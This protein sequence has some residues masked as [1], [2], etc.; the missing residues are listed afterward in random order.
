[1]EISDPSQR[2]CLL[3]LESAFKLQEQKDFC[4]HLISSCS[5]SLCDDTLPRRCVH[6]TNLRVDLYDPYTN[7]TKSVLRPVPCGKCLYCLSRRSNDYYVRFRV[8]QSKALG[9][10][11]ITLTYSEDYFEPLNVDTVQKFIKR[12]RRSGIK[13]RYVLLGEYGPRTCRPHYHMLCFFYSD[14][15]RSLQVIRDNWSYY[16]IVD[17]KNVTDS[18]L[19]YVAKYNAKLFLNYATIHLFSKSPPIGFDLTDPTS[20]RILDDFSLE[21]TR[22]VFDASSG[23]SYSLP[24]I[25]RKK[26]DSYINGFTESEHCSSDGTY[27]MPVISE[28]EYARYSRD[29]V[30][31][32]NSFINRKL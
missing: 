25:Y 13:F 31:A 28:S 18:H 10:A 17:V 14:P 15:H 16:G 24:R 12:V 30:K 8:E 11:F 29:Y 26:L 3:D 23:R 5:D 9:S 21:G 27:P 7:R 32:F 20:T 22:T 1:M 2:I 19:Y 6:P 4:D